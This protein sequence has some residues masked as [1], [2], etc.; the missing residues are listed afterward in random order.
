M[1]AH[2]WDDTDIDIVGDGIHSLGGYDIAAQEKQITERYDGWR[3][4]DVN[5]QSRKMFEKPD[6][7]PWCHIQGFALVCDASDSTLRTL[8]ACLWRHLLTRHWLCWYYLSIFDESKS[9]FRMISYDF[10]L[11]IAD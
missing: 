9:I 6:Q 2:A 8:F 10:C 1:A 3:I 11:E 4:F 7:M 5:A